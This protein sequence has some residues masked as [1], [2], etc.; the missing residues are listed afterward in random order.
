MNWLY[1]FTYLTQSIHES[2]SR[3]FEQGTVVLIE[4]ILVGLAFMILFAL[5]GLVL[6]YAERKVSA[7]FQQRLGP[8]RVGK[9]GTAQTLADV[10]KLLMKEPLINKNADKF[11]FNLAPYIIMITAFMTMAALPFA[12]GLQALDFDIGLLYISAVSSL[13]V[14]GIL[15]AGWSSDNKYSLIGALRSGAQVI[16]YELSVGLSLLTIVILTGS[17]QLSVI[18]ESQANGW[19]I[20]KGH[21]PAVIAFI[22][23]L[24][25]STAETNRGPFDLAE[26]ESELTAG[27]HTEYS[28]MKFAFFFL[29]EFANMFIVSALGATVFLGGWMPFHIGGWEVFNNI[30]DY[31]PPIFWFFGK[32]SFIIFLMMWFR[33]T[34]PRLRIDQLLTLEWKYLLPIN[35]MNILVMAFLV[36]MGW[37]F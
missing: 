5:L 27:F 4:M 28:G 2:L 3:N 32:V 31:I 33:W 16:S 29:A 15:L 26:A 30:M 24:I 35:L 21:I 6:V 12:K 11:L 25:A 20:F 9:W 17:L 18:V 14:V 19:W 13:G 34:F 37:Y 8:M 7:F 23:F 10:I 36:L 1:D 22:I